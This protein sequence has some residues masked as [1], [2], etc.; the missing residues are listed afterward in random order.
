[1]QLMKMA[2]TEGL[3][4]LNVLR[5]LFSAKKKKAKHFGKMNS[6]PSSFTT[7]QKK[8]EFGIETVMETPEE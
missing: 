4:L 7:T 6:S 5:I 3:I 8:T 2:W 1:M